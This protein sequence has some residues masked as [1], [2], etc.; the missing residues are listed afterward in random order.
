MNFTFKANFTDSE[1]VKLTELASAKN[2]TLTTFVRHE[3]HK[4][5]SSLECCEPCV[6]EPHKQRHLELSL[7]EDTIKK[8][9]CRSQALNLFPANVVSMILREKIISL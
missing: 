6:V 7:T 1:W 5:I 2:M 4:S 9:H 3:V 8:L